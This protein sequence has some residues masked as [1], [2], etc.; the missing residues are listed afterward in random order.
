MEHIGIILICLLD[1]LVSA[2]RYC[3]VTFVIM[4][5]PAGQG[6]SISSRRRRR[7]ISHQP[8]PLS[9]RSSG[10]VVDSPG[11]LSCINPPKEGD[12]HKDSQE[13]KVE[14]VVEHFC[15]KF[16]NSKTQHAAKL[17]VEK[18]LDVDKERDWLLSARTHHFVSEMGGNKLAPYVLK[19]EVVEGCKVD[20]SVNLVE[21]VKDT[22]CREIFHSAWK[23]V[24]SRVGE[25]HCKLAA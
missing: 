8:K 17:P 3:L 18:T 24:T 5:T 4:Q 10:K 23:H 2:A 14:S 19:V 7:M 11:K 22:K 9:E 12:E 25:G 16:A 6:Q 1:R 21:P 13:G 20:G 15:N